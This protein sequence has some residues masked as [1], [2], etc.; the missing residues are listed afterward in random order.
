[1]VSISSTLLPAPISKVPTGTVH[2][3]TSLSQLPMWP[4]P[5]KSTKF[6]H[7]YGAGSESTGFL[8]LIKAFIVCS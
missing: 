1:M 7:T 3:P 8:A 4:H 5:E 2:E 6:V